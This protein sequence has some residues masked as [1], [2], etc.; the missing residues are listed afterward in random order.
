MLDLL[1]SKCAEGGSVNNRLNKDFLSIIR[2]GK[3]EFN[4]SL[5]QTTGYS[6]FFTNSSVKTYWNNRVIIT[7]FLFIYVKK[8]CQK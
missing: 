2:G 7:I 3:L 6:K 4:F 8:T 1:L 5:C